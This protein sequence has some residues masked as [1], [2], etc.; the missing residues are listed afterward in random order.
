M[1]EFEQVT[2]VQADTAEG[3]DL[4]VKLCEPCLET[5][6]NKHAVQY[7]KE[8]DEYMCIDC[9]KRHRTTKITKSHLP[10]SVEEK[11]MQDLIKCDPCFADNKAIEASYFCKICEEYLC[12][13]CKTAHNRF[14]ASKTHEVVTRE[15]A[16]NDPKMSDSFLCLCDPCKDG[17]SEK[18]A[19][20]YCSECKEF[21]CNE[22]VKSHKI[23][24]VTRDHKIVSAE[25]HIASKQETVTYKC[26]P[27]KVLGTEKNSQ[28]YCNECDECLCE[29]CARLHGVQK[30]TKNHKL[31]EPKPDKDNKEPVYIDCE[32]CKGLNKSTRA[33]FYCLQCEENYCF[34]CKELH[35]AQ[36]L[37]RNHELRDAVEFYSENRRLCD[38]CKL[39]NK[40]PQTGLFYCNECEEYLCIDCKLR[41]GVSK[42][43]KDHTYRS[44]DEAYQSSNDVKVKCE[45]CNAMGTESIAIALCIDCDNEALCGT[46]LEMHNAQKVT[47]NHRASSDLHLNRQQ[48]KLEQ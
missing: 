40:T 11:M 30:S 1:S 37:S 3:V 5:E 43:S 16:K 36:K 7:C 17:G 34:D 26:G 31:V 33:A 27:C 9:L 8:C 25:D 28:L 13:S 45:P 4:A 20:H 2:S 21:I 23:L 42:Y 44:A 15:E 12:D 46:C 47:K 29:D 39:M 14:K 6:E 35:S 10:I 24:R 32:P 22:C 18:P 41:H 48:T 19:K 38:T